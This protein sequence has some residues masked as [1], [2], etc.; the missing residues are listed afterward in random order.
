MK[1]A[2]LDSVGYSSSIGANKTID[3]TFSTQIGG[4]NDNTNGIQMSG[5]Y[6]GITIFS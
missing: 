3:L 4:V 6:S 2:Q 1:N 5:S